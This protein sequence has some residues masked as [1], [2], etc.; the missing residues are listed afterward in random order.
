ML[1]NQPYRCRQKLQF[2]VQRHNCRHGK[3]LK[4]RRT[5]PTRFLQSTWK[6]AIPGQPA[7]PRGQPTNG[8]QHGGGAAATTAR[9]GQFAGGS[10]T[11]TADAAA[12]AA[13]LRGGQAPPVPTSPAVAPTEGNGG[14]TVDGA[15]P[16]GLGG[17][18]S[19]WLQLTGQQG[20]SQSASRNWWA[21]SEPDHSAIVTLDRSPPI[22]TPRRTSSRTS[23]GI[24]EEQDRQVGDLE[25]TYTKKTGDTSQ[26]HVV[27]MCL[28]R[29]S[30]WCTEKVFLTQ[31]EKA[32][33][34]CLCRNRVYMVSRSNN[35]GTRLSRR[36]AKSSRLTCVVSMHRQ[37]QMQLRWSD[38]C[39]QEELS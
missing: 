27:N 8:G 36:T 10:S 6:A 1:T 15:N 28:A 5:G 22:S 2:A 26:R 9:C 32:G 24:R 19:R 21:R 18:N 17:R 14:T 35:Q 37:R 39:C 11:T 12:P 33:F 20:G 3:R 34:R 38:D 25:D 30:S 23:Q 4:M 31:K 16:L 29:G 7:N 13:L